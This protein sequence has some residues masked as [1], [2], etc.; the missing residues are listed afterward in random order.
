MIH[1]AHVASIGIYYKVDL[2]CR[3]RTVG[4]QRFSPKREMAVKDSCTTYKPYQ[5]KHQRGVQLN[6][7]AVLCWWISG[8]FASQ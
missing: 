2:T 6:G 1:Q 8:L 4:L 7:N 3:F 5:I